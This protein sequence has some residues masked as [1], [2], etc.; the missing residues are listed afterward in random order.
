MAH[1]EDQA[2]TTRQRFFT[3]IPIHPLQEP[4]VWSLTLSYTGQGDNVIAAALPIQ[5]YNP[6]HFDSRTIVIP[7][8]L[9]SQLTFENVTAE[10]ETL[11]QLWDQYS[12]RP[13]APDVWQSPLALS[14]PVS[15]GF[16][17]RRV[18]QWPLAEPYPVN[19]HSGHDF[20]SPLGTPVHAPSAGLVVLAEDLL[21]KGKAVI[22]DHGR[23]VM[24]GYWH[25]DQI[26][27]A[28]GEEV[29][30]GQV[31]GLV[32]NTGI[33]LGPHLHWELRIQGV[34]VAP[35]QFLTLPLVPSETQE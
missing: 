4:G 22:L 15:A 6:G 34:P 16:G 21:T 18:Y 30:T 14:Y 27:V 29:T 9:A 10:I 32:G 8:T 20:A 28:V 11:Q 5:I 17:Q 31:L 23:G 35:L 3:H 1:T 26:A 24:T 25:L 12:E 7:N 13:W 19:F 33:S 2:A